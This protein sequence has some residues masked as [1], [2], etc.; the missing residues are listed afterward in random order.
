M[1]TKFIALRLV[2]PGSV[3]LGLA[4]A[5]LLSACG[6]GGDDSPVHVDTNIN[7]SGRIALAENAS[8]A[9]HVLDID[10]GKLEAT[11]QLD[12]TPSALYVSPGGRYVTAVQRLQDQVQFVDGGLWQED[13]VDHLHDYKQASRLVEWKLAGARPTHFDVQT[14]KQAAF[15]MDGNAAATPVQ[16]AS[17][18]LITDASIAAGNTVATLNLSLP[19]HGLG[20]PVDNKLLTVHRAPDAVDTLP[21]HLELYQRAGSSYT[22][23]RRLP[24]RCDGMHGSF[25]SGSYTVA[26]CKDGVLLYNNS[27]AAAVADQKLL[28]PVR[29]STLVGHSKLPGQFI[30]IGND[31][32][33]PAVVTTQ[34]YAINSDTASTMA[35]VP[36][37]WGTGRTRV[38]HGFDRSGT[39]FYILDDQ[40]TLIVMQRQGSGWTTAARIAGAVSSIPA[41]AP[42]P[43][44]TANGARDEVYL[45]DPAAKQLVTISSLTS[46]V[47]SR[48]DLGYA[49]LALVWT[50]INR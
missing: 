41:A 26:G 36:T 27:A 50:G 38:T 33:A 17:V 22:L 40:G 5:G 16:N 42:R 11:H 9:L 43:S 15:F 47:T 1:P 14:G 34:L 48:K 20:E 12:H 45:S 46:T 10:T 3:L 31:G 19:I 18:Q 49:P 32:V 44:F 21:T 39:R 6:G 4:T 35:L 13:H 2:S 23:E 25:S 24:T 7:T 28:T 30:G 29:I 37:G 8:K